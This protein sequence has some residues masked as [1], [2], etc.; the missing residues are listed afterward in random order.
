MDNE[1]ESVRLFDLQQK[2]GQY[3]QVSY[4]R[5]FERLKKSI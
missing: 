5:I 4:P 2:Y 1:F 3:I